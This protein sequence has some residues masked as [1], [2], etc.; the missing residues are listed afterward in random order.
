MLIKQKPLVQ[1]YTSDSYRER[2]I[3]GEAW[4][5]LGWSGDLLQADEELRNQATHSR[6]K[7]I[8]PVQGTMLWMDSMVIPRRRERGA[9][10]RVYQLP[11]RSDK[12][13][14]QRAEG[15]LRHT[16]CRRPRVVA[17]GRTHQY[18]HLFA[19]RLMNRCSWLEDRGRNIEKIERVWRTVRG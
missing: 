2:L 9:G 12:R 17:A 8:I 15:E 5:A 11:A 19:R 3:S 4:A 16:Q 6:V 14:R 1:A 7:V 18:Q 13:S 10:T